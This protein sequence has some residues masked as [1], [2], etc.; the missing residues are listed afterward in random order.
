ME[1]GVLGTA[2]LLTRGKVVN[3]V[4]EWLQMRFAEQEVLQVFCDT[5]EAVARLPQCKTREMHRDL[6]LLLWKNRAKCQGTAAFKELVCLLLISCQTAN[7]GKPLVVDDES[8]INIPALAAAHVI[9]GY[10]AQAPDE[11]SFEVGDIVCVIDMPPKEVTRWWRGKHGFQVGF[12]PSEC[13][14]PIKDKVPQSVID[15]VPKPGMY[16]PLDGAGK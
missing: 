14:E 11:L 4:N 7:K 3:L 2:E 15:L 16:V 6:Q 5:H 1:A 12:F 8:A 9:K 13:V 10:T